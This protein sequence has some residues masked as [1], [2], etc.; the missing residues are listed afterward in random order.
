MEATYQYNIN[1]KYSLFDMKTYFIRL[2]NHP[3]PWLHFKT[4]TVCKCS[5]SYDVNTR[6]T[7]NSRPGWLNKWNTSEACMRWWI[8]YKKQLLNSFSLLQITVC[9]AGRFVTDCE[10]AKGRKEAEKQQQTL[11]YRKGRGRETRNAP[12]YYR[13]R[14]WM[15]YPA[16]SQI[17]F[18]N[19]I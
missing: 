4:T 13:M 15:I 3:S 8:L 14:R 9:S 16:A 11:P 12:L 2:L 6:L 1:C 7:N 17:S 10:I 18:V 5:R 19:I